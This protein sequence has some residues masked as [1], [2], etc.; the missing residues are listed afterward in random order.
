LSCNYQSNGQSADA[1]KDGL[2]PYP[3]L[4]GG[5]HEEDQTGAISQ[6]VMADP[7]FFYRGLAGLYRKAV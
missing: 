2:Q 4:Q 1:V 3:G 6:A 5:S 7:A